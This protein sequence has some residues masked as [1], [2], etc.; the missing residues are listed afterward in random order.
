M[1]INWLAP[2]RAW[3]GLTRRSKAPL[4]RR[5]ARR[6]LRI[7]S[8]EER[9]V[10]A[11]LI[12]I[13]DF[14]DTFETAFPLALGSAGQ[15][16]LV[17]Q[18]NGSSDVD[19]L[20]LHAPT[21]GTQSVRV[22]GLNENTVDFRLEAFDIHGAMIASN[23]NSRGTIDPTL[24]FDTVANGEYYIRIA[25][26]PLA[27]AVLLAPVSYLV[28][29]NP[30]QDDRT[31]LPTG[32]PLSLSSTTSQTYTGRIDTVNDVDAFRFRA[33]ATT[34][35]VFTLAARN[36]SPLD[37]YLTLTDSRGVVVG[38]SD[39]IDQSSLTARITARVR[40]GEFY[41]ITAAASP[42]AIPAGTVGDYQLQVQPFADEAGGFR[43]D[44][45]PIIVSLATG[46]GSATGNI[47]APG[48]ADAYRFTTLRGGSYLVEVD[49][50]TASGAAGLSLSNQ[51]DNRVGTRIDSRTIR[52]EARAG[53]EFL[54][55]V[56]GVDSAT[57]SYTIR[58]LPLADDGDNTLA[59]ATSLVLDQDGAG[60]LNGRTLETVGDIDFIR[61]SNTQTGFLNLTV[62][63]ISTGWQ[64]RMQVFDA[65]GRRL[66]DGNNTLTVGVSAR[67]DVFVGIDARSRATGA[68]NFSVIT[69][70]D[71]VANTLQA[72]TFL[73]LSSEFVE[74]DD[75]IDLAFDAD[76]YRLVAPSDGD[77]TITL[78]SINGGLGV[79]D[80]VL[81]VLAENGNQLAFNDDSNGLNSRVDL[82]LSQGQ[83]F[84]VRAEGFADE[85]G[86]YRL[87]VERRSVVDQIGD[88]LPEALG[89]NFNSGNSLTRSDRIQTEF[90]ADLYRIVAPVSGEYL[91]RLEGAG[92]GAL[93]DPVLSVLDS[94]GTLI[95]ENDDADGLNSRLNLTFSEGETYY[96]RARAY[97]TLTGNYR[98]SILAL[99]GAGTQPG[100]EPQT[101]TLSDSGSAVQSGILEFGGET[102]LYQITPTFSGRLRI[103][104]SA[105]GNSTLDSLLTVLTV[106][107]SELN[108]DDDS[109]GSLNSDLTMDVVEG[110]T[111]LVRAGGYRT[112]TGAYQLTFS[113]GIDA[114]MDLANRRSEAVRLTLDSNNTT[115]TVSSIDIAGDVDW[116]VYTATADGFLEIEQN[117]EQSGLDSLLGVYDSTGDLITATGMLLVQNDD[118]NGSLNSAVSLRVTNG[119]TYYLLAGAFGQSSGNYRLN[120]NLTSD[121]VGNT[122][123]NSQLLQL[124]D[125]TAEFN[126][127]LRPAT[128]VDVFA[129]TLPNSGSYLIREI[130]T[131][132]S[133][134]RPQV[135]WIDF[136]G[137]LLSG[138]VVTSRGEAQ[139]TVSG[140][141]G[142]TIYVRARRTDSPTV[143]TAENS[144][145]KLTVETYQDDV[146]NRQLGSGS[147]AVSASGAGFQSGRIEVSGDQ[148][149]FQF[150]ASLSGSYDL[151]MVAVNGSAL[152]SLLEVYTADGTRIA[153]NDDTLE[154]R[155]INSRI[156]FTAVSGESYFI[157][158]SGS[159]GSRI[160]TSTGNYELLIQRVISN[161]ELNNRLNAATPVPVGPNGVGNA[162]GSLLEV[163][164]QDTRFLMIPATGS[165][166]ITVSPEM[167][168]SVDPRLSLYRQV[169]PHGFEL[170][171]R[172]DNRATFGDSAGEIVVSA[173][174]GET[175]FL[176]VDSVAVNPSRRV[177]DYRIA[178]RPTVN[179]QPDDHDFR[180]EN[181]TVVNLSIDQR[182]II[183]GVIDTAYDADRFQFTPASSG[184]FFLYR[185]TITGLNPRVELFDSNGQRVP[186]IFIQSGGV[187]EYLLFG[188]ETYQV[189]VTSS[190]VSESLLDQP[191]TTGAYRFV[192]RS[193]VDDVPGITL[194]TFAPNGSV[195]QVGLIETPGDVDLYE[196]VAV[197]S[198]LVQFDLTRFNSNLTLDPILTVFD[199]L[200]N[201]LAMND[202][203][204]GTTD[205]RVSL[206]VVEGQTYFVQAWAFGVSSGIYQL[207]VSPA[208]PVGGNSI[209]DA[210]TL[211]LDDNLSFSLTTGINSFGD[212]DTFRFIAPSTGQIRFEMSATPGSALDPDLFI[213]TGNGFFIANFIFGAD[214]RR[215]ELVLD[216]VAGEE[217]LLQATSFQNSTRGDYRLTA[218][219]LN[220]V[221]LGAEPVSRQGNLTQQTPIQRYELLAPQDGIVTAIVEPLTAIDPVE[222]SIT[223][224]RL[225]FEFL[226]SSSEDF[227][228]RGTQV[229]FNVQAGQRLFV[230][231][232][233]LDAALSSSTGEYRVRFLFGPSQAAPIRPATVIQTFSTDSTV[234][235][236]IP[237]PGISQVQSFVATSN[238]IMTV[239]LEST[240]E[241]NYSIWNDQNQLLA[242]SSDT[243]T[244]LTFTATARE[245]YFVRVTTPD[246]TPPTLE[247]Y[248]LAI[249][250]D[251]AGGQMSAAS[252]ITL[253]NGS[254]TLSGTVNTAD[255][256]DFF[257]STA[258]T[259][260][261]VTIR[262][263][264]V[265]GFRLNS[266]LEVYDAAGNL[267]GTG[268]QSVTV[269]LNE[270]D[271]FFVR[272]A[273]T[274]P[275]K[276]D[277]AISS[278]S[279][280]L[281]NPGSNSPSGPIGSFPSIADPGFDIGESLTDSGSSGGGGDSSGG[282]ST[283][284]AVMGLALFGDSESF[285]D[286]DL[287]S[288]QNLLNVGS[289]EGTAELLIAVLLVG[290][291]DISTNTEEDEPEEENLPDESEEA[292]LL[293]LNAA[294][295]QEAIRSLRQM[296]DRFLQRLHHDFQFK[297]SAE[298]QELIDRLNTTEGREAVEGLRLLFSTIDSLAKNVPSV[299][300]PLQQ[301][302][303]L[304]Q[305]WF[306]EGLAPQAHPNAVPTPLDDLLIPDPQRQS[307]LPVEERSQSPFHFVLVALAMLGMASMDRSRN[308]E[309]GIGDRESGIG[310][311]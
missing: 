234:T 220:T 180:P 27:G 51:V 178:V 46:T 70:G 275:G 204:P 94:T 217:I 2:I 144:A 54:A 100:G 282:T 17:G 171:A 72:A 300:E 262:F 157:R 232:A 285:S 226:T 308:R 281:G 287:A 200:G 13:D 271:Q 181:A 239:E 208:D 61:I 238:G 40:Q 306:P 159:N 310:N 39:N 235:S 33:E 309:S 59:T 215:V 122:P 214:P 140:L 257:T 102:D 279:S 28:Q 170:V 85:F 147:L 256:V 92:S 38:Q 249:R 143:L 158:A 297:P 176:L 253:S 68:F 150:I 236:L 162:N 211:T 86:Q 244:Q 304:W 224:R 125:G 198:G 60:S 126:G 134:V 52:F 141:A 184:V 185:D 142:D 227:E 168:S 241:L 254:T 206:E 128:D 277:L 71:S 192:L 164:S 137:N 15:T 255:D 49:A 182:G 50:G 209:F 311:R 47:G 124:V 58:V 196:Y 259:T 123:E 292:L 174:A 295:S 114:S 250:P 230:D 299:K 175:Y 231:V 80:P 183:S 172:N 66:S 165:Y 18:F 44:S 274:E 73:D 246:V 79:G 263:E 156:I 108:S 290:G 23:D 278:T 117:A 233:A 121:D 83:V 127:T 45:L 11:P 251:D 276:Y 96:V 145:Y 223:V 5:N 97:S 62:T 41:T 155:S 166:T 129:V 4:R 269:S 139:V 242:S 160:D 267:L 64:P 258:S 191:S 22:L 136:N 307:V 9:R 104:Q 149:V 24:T 266:S 55:R 25:G 36:G 109:G 111:Y 131:G 228:Q 31:N 56:S 284:T 130:A 273:A 98:L 34:G 195:T 265:P 298:L 154:L 240:T 6:P 87:T 186:P 63:P 78:D 301:F 245:T 291:E 152:D 77:Y 119:T 3:L 213:T 48:D 95:A 106:S 237:L 197:G 116:F 207:S 21:V 84:F 14:G 216:V 16:T 153:R 260:G 212:Q 113:R 296:L 132:Q 53:E 169:G 173:L 29:A 219:Y 302:L 75:Q 65:D 229:Q 248:T 32:L 43:E 57:F 280:D 93:S 188:G 103:Q 7:E 303:D 81:T 261:A 194:L 163:D 26:R 270:G 288:A 133:Q 201:L 293:K 305:Q 10:L 69:V 82:R 222:T 42:F 8:L 210:Q 135:E 37:S 205:S 118:S 74:R 283:P 89:L 105:S 19:V 101:I 264:D 187:V 91:L 107:G 203:N 30:Y 179:L 202:D 90:D 88:T 146:A 268:S 294:A 286:R 138:G 110:T 221:I 35:V 115:T 161:S 199:S 67:Q 20:L 148:D 252:N 272:V 225:D 12:G 177:G 151:R 1:I 99:D 189:V 243:A 120:L 193:A 190:V 112:S 247:T 76:L 218:S 289:L 167:G